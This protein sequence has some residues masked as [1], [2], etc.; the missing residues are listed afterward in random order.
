M[1]FSARQIRVALVREGFEELRQHGSHL[2]L[3][4]MDLDGRI[5]RVVI[6]MHR[7]DLKPGT[8]REILREAGLTEDDVRRLLRG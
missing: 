5:R 2:I 8:L 4:R 3:W 1:P 6:P 7:G